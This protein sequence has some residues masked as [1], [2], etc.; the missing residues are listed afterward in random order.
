MSQQSLPKV[1]IVFGNQEEEVS[2]SRFRLIR[3]ALPRGEEDGEVIDVRPPGNLPLKLEKAVGTLIDEMGTISLI[4]EMKRVIVVYQ[5][6]DFRN[7]QSGSLREAK[8]T[9]KSKGDPVATLGE[10]IRQVHLQSNNLLLFVF[11]EDDE[12]NKTVNKTS[13]LFQLVSSLGPVF[14]HR[15]KRMDWQVEE[16][17]LNGDLSTSVTLIRDWLE[18]GG[19]ASFRLVNT[20]NNVLQLLLQARLIQEARE[21]GKN[22]T[23]IYANLRPSLENV[24]PP[25]KQQ[26]IHSLASRIPLPAIR[27]ALQKFNRIQCS[28]YPMG[29]EVVVHDPEEQIEVMLAELFSVLRRP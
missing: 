3:E 22:T 6:D 5:M 2:E 24:K 25:F 26:K 29:T 9:S 11:E 4:P 12:K 28:F 27:R 15:E 16:A 7:A 13:A 14:E 17:L 21:A 18:R 20:L 8:S 23:N 10:Y 1:A 19:N